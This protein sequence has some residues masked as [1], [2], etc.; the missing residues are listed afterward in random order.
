MSGYDYLTDAVSSQ[1]GWATMVVGRCPYNC[2]RLDCPGDFHKTLEK[3]RSLG[4]RGI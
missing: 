1:E 3:F 4:F 2:L